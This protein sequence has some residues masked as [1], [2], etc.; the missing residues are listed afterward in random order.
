MSV[1]ADLPYELLVAIF[2]YCLQGGIKQNA[3]TI[4]VCSHVCR[5]WRESS[6]SSQRLWRF[7]DLTNYKLA[8]ESFKRSQ[9]TQVHVT[10]YAPW[11]TH[12]WKALQLAKCY[13]SRIAAIDATTTRYELTADLL[14]IINSS[15]SLSR[16]KLDNRTTW[17][18]FF[19][20][21]D[22][23]SVRHLDLHGVSVG[24]GTCTNLTYL[25]LSRLI[26]EYAPTLV[27]I[28]GVFERSP[29]L[30]VVEMDDIGWDEDVMPA[31]IADLRILFG[32]L[33]PSR[34]RVANLLRTISV[35]PTA[36]VTVSCPKQ[37]LDA[38]VPARGNQWTLH[39]GEEG[40]LRIS[41]TGIQAYDET[42]SA[43]K[44]WDH[45]PM[46]S[47]TTE[48]TFPAEM[49]EKHG[50][51]FGVRRVRNLEIFG[52]WSRINVTRNQW[53]DSFLLLDQLVSI[54]VQSSYSADDL[55]R[56]ILSSLSPRP[57]PEKSPASPPEMVCPD[58]RF[59]SFKILRVYSS[60]TAD[61]LISL[62]RTLAE[63]RLAAGGHPLTVRVLDAGAWRTVSCEKQRTPILIL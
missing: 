48:K 26:G 45:R 53:R 11:F 23:S 59:V 7:I 38:F 55:L 2:D 1:A 41:S 10:I 15:S 5:M 35:P 18:S 25:R 46:L 32:K 54:D 9:T 36:K 50:T 8:F 4:V 6:L 63:Q 51:P 44:R 42:Y 19:R 57:S 33:E 40:L 3:K 31:S 52:A 21:G 60:A 61:V 30:T 37:T 27:E 56:N 20:I 29:Q 47:V 14:Q 12:Y 43:K 39:F 62:A 28:G 22:V 24:W 17:D 16:I 49:I 13:A 34:S 58:L